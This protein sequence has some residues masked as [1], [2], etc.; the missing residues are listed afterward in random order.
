MCNPAGEAIFGPQG[1]LGEWLTHSYLFIAVIIGWYD[2]FLEQPDL[3]SATAC[4]TGQAQVTIGL[5]CQ[6]PPPRCSP[7]KALLQ[8]IGLDDFLKRVA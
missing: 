8:Q 3:A 5:Q 4:R 6:H 1:R 2:L 7:D